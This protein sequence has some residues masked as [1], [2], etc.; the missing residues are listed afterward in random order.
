MA[1]FLDGATQH[2]LMTKYRRVAVIRA[3]IFVHI[4]L[5]YIAPVFMLFILLGQIDSFFKLG[6]F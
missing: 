3:R 1:I 2:I 4:C 6:L 5:K